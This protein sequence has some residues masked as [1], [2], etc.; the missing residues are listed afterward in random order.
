MSLDA[1]DMRIHVLGIGSIGSLFAFHLRRALPESTPVSLIVRKRRVYQNINEDQGQSIRVERDGHTEHMGGFDREV[2]EVAS[3]QLFS[4]MYDRRGRVKASTDKASDPYMDVFHLSKEELKARGRP[5]QPEIGKATTIDSLI[6]T[7]KAPSTLPALQR[8][9]PRLHS[10]STIVLLQNGMGVYD[11]IVD[12]LFPDPNKRPH[13]VLASTT[14]GV[15]AK[16][17]LSVV[18]AGVGNFSFGIVPDPRG[19]RDHEASLQHGFERLQLSD[20]SSDPRNDLEF[21]TLHGTIQALLTLTDLN[22]IWDP[23]QWLNVKL[24]KKLCVNCCVNPITAIMNIT[25]GELL[26][27]ADAYYML[28]S[29]CREANA[30]FRAQARAEDALVPATVA[31]AHLHPHKLEE[32]VTR[33]IG[34]T[35]RNFSSMLQDMRNGKPTEIEYMNGYLMRMGQKYGVPTPVNNLLRSM[36]RLKSSIGQATELPGAEKWWHPLSDLPRAK[37][38]PPTKLTAKPPPFKR[39]SML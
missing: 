17:P 9:V 13:F 14:H 38:P 34:H 12:R 27:S 19:R 35:S 3:D 20:I 25:N 29:V 28:R 11:S 6:I 22:P 37:P 16:G 36:V 8:L 21:R 30:V 1:D 32:E 23:I 5:K 24:L 2:W 7:C 4:L 10:N 18:H 26:G 39:F 33:V 15:W 31:L